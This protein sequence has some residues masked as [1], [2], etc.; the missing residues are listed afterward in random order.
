LGILQPDPI[1]SFL[2]TTCLCL[3]YGRKEYWSI[4][5]KSGNNVFSLSEPP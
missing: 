2:M 4:R 3:R 5:G 1:T